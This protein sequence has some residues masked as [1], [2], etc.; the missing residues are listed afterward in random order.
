VN[1]TQRRRKKN[2][3]GVVIGIKHTL[4]SQKLN[5]RSIREAY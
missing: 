5:S 3:I 4:G 1:M 2:L